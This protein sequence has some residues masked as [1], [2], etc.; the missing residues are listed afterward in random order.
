MDDVPAFGFCE[1]VPQPPRV[2]PYCRAFVG[3][4]PAAAMPWTSLDEGLALAA[5]VQRPCRP[6]EG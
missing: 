2:T 6:R 3:G 5:Q 1:D 4:L